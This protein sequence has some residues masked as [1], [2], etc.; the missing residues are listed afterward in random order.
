MATLLELV[1]RLGRRIVSLLDE[2]P[3]LCSLKWFSGAA[4]T[5]WRVERETVFV[6]YLRRDSSEAMRIEWP[7]DPQV[8]RVEVA[9]VS[10][11]DAWLKN[12]DSPPVRRSMLERASGVPAR[13]V[14]GPTC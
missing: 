13:I 7:P 12:G 14:R 4:V 6:M 3:V 9:V 10:P 11:A 8:V 1:E 5:T 2:Q